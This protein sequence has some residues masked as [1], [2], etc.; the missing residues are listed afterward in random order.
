[1]PSTDVNLNEVLWRKSRHSMNHG[2]CVEVAQVASG[3]LVRDSA[4][5]EG[6]VVPCSP[7]AWRAFVGTLK[8]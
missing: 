3:L 1:M 6:S 8:S 7:A 4:N 5:A 2:A